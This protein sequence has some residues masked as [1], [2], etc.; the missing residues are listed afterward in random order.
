MRSSPALFLGLVLL[1]HGCSL[2]PPFTPAQAAQEIVTLCRDKYQLDVTTRLIEQTIYAATQMPGFLRRLV[3]LGT[4]APQDSDTIGDLLITTTQ[5][6]LGA[7]PPIQFY[8]LRLTDPEAPGTELRYVTYLD[9]IRRLYAGALSESE[10]FDRRIQEIKLRTDEPVMS[11]AWLER[12]VTLGEF[13]AVQ[14]ALRIKA[15]VLQ[16]PKLAEWQL[17]TCV[18]AFQEGT[19]S[20]TAVT[21]ASAP[22]ALAGEPWPK[23]VL[24]L[25]ARVLAEY[26][27]NDYHRVLLTDT[28]TLITHQLSPSDLQPYLLKR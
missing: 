18:G 7:T 8:M 3:E 14:L 1:Q 26:N 13:L 10:F 19:F 5:M 6:S 2:E 24:Q 27:F 9:D 17:D 4:F 28:S 15:L 25:I 12:D 23:P 22:L 16:E 21:Q 11:D 20:F